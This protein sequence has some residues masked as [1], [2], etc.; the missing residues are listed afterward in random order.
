VIKY[1]HD[2]QYGSD[3]DH[4]IV[5]KGYFVSTAGMECEKAAFRRLTG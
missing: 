1:F 4:A 3:D 5:P 2:N